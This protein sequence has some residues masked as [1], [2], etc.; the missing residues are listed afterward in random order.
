MKITHQKMDLQLKLD[1]W[2]SL[3]LRLSAFT[4]LITEGYRTLLAMKE[5]I[6]NRSIFNGRTISY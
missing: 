6:W 1:P 3:N 2:A 4:K 5:T